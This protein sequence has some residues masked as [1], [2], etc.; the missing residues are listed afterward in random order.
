MTNQH[1]LASSKN[2]WQE[3]FDNSL[4]NARSKQQYRQRQSRRIS[5][6]FD[7]GSN[8]YLGLSS[9]PE[10]IGAARAEQRN[11]PD[12][13]GVENRETAKWGTGASPIIGGYTASHAKLE[14]A[15]ASLFQLEQALVF[16]S[17]YA[18]NTGVIPCL[19]G[20]RDLILSDQLNHA[21]LI[22]GCRLSK[23]TRVIYPHIDA[24][25]IADQLHSCRHQFDKVLIVTE[26]V[27]SMDGDCAP[28]KELC[29]LADEFDCAVAVDEAHGTGILGENGGGL[30]EEVQLHSQRIIKLGTLSKAIGSVGG[31]VAGSKDLID[32][33]V[34]HCRSYIFSTACPAAVAA[35]T[36]VGVGLV[37]RLGESRAHLQALSKDL[38]AQLNADRWRTNEANSPIIPIF[39]GSEM[40][41]LRLSSA[42]WELGFHVPAIRPPT[43]PEATSRLRISLT[44]EH[45]RE[46]IDRLLNALAGCR[47]I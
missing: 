42:L 44:A 5:R 28:L 45:T 14:K 33:L 27:F 11:M 31:Y 17:G 4:G 34:N 6:R 30:L 41:A 36:A 21:S 32:F 7:F 20:S 2:R 12:S 9:H 25:F 38:R 19:V 16:S 24:A 10:V 3:F 15:L 37:A 26:S 8:D 35:T 1:R 46:D 29:S 22:D 43:V 13:C 39:I 40:D 47:R 18:C 23:A